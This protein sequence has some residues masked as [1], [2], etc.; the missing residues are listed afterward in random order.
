MTY[1]QEHIED[2]GI[3]RKVDAGPVDAL[4]GVLL[5]LFGEDGLV[6]VVLELL[7]GDVDTELLKTILCVKVLKTGEVQ[8]T[9][10]S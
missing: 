1:V 10:L 4:G 3:V 5:L 7:V 2:V 8:Y 9:D 6:E